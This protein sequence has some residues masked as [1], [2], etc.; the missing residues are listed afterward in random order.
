[1]CCICINVRFAKFDLWTLLV[2]HKELRDGD[3]FDINRKLCSYLWKCNTKGIRVSSLL[4]IYKQVEKWKF[5]FL[6]NYLLRLSSIFETPFL[7]FST[8]TLESLILQS[9]I[10]K[11][12]SLIWVYALSICI[13]YPKIPSYLRFC[14]R[15]LNSSSSQ[16]CMLPLIV[17]VSYFIKVMSY[18]FFLALEL[19]KFN[20]NP[21]ISDSCLKGFSFFSL[22]IWK[23]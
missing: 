18:L 10:S 11:S 16:L 22:V 2:A 19:W 13:T 3:L 5:N 9:L 12:Q 20:L 8:K 4:H 14:H 17:Y 15:E 1:M 6:Q 21:L 23:F 7:Q